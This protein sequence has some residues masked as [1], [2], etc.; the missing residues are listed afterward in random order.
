MTANNLIASKKHNCILIATDAAAY[1]DEGTVTEFKSKIHAIPEWPAV[2]TGR[3]NS[4]GLDTGAREL[5]KR[6]SSFDE[7]IGI[8]SRELPLIVE[9]FRLYRPF[10]LNL[11][12]FFR[13]CPSLFFIRTPGHDSSGIGLRPYLICPVGSTFFGPWPS[14]ELVAA[15]GFV[16]PDPDDA[17]EDIVNGLR[18]LI[19]LQRRT[20]A[21]DG[22]SRVGGY[23][24]LTTISPDGIETQ[25]FHRWPDDQIGQRMS[26][27]E[28]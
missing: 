8:V 11:A 1:L 17:P 28:H 19:N 27:M 15:T 22:Y 23:A 5:Q 7:L 14:D 26:T 3:G 12:G 20:P 9:E 25:I 6:A 18:D 10:E 4:F 16:A 24:E 21:D 2:I 13:G